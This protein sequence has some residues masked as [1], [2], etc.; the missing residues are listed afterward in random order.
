MENKNMNAQ[1]CYFGASGGFFA[2]WHILLGTDYNCFLTDSDQGYEDIK[3]ESWPAISD[4]P[5]TILELSDKMQE[6]LTINKEWKLIVEQ[7][8]KNRNNG[9]RSI[10]DIFYK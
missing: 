10:N 7:T 3:G 9:P 2:L 5:A 4:L 1:L 8:M 6:E